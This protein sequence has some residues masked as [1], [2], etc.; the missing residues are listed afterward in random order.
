M[1]SGC[2]HGHRAGSVP[3][4]LAQT[5]TEWARAEHEGGPTLP[6]VDII[7]LPRDEN[8]PSGRRFGSLVHAV[9]ASVPFGAD[10]DVIHRL[11]ELESRTLGATDEEAAFAARVVEVVL[12]QPILERAREAARANRCRRE[13]PISWRHDDRLIEGVVDLAFEEEG[14]WTLV[15]FKTDE[16]LADEAPYRRQLGLY[17]LAVGAASGQPVSA[18]LM[19]V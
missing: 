1:A 18:F 16:E 17:A 9:L 12:A 14:Q 19:R 7:E 2:G 6:P 10:S 13:T 3:S 5:V 8:R 15:D 4:I 11:S